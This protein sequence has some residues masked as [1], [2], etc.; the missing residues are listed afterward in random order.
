MMQLWRAVLAATIL[1]AGLGA[2]EAAKDVVVGVSWANFS[3]DRW[4][5][6]ERA[7]KA[8]LDRAGA[9]YESYDAS[10]SAAKQFVDVQKLIAAKVDV[11]VIIAIDAQALIPLVHQAE[12]QRIPVIAYDRLIDDPYAYYISF[13]SMEVGRMQARALLAAR[14]VGDYAILKGDPGDPNTGFLYSGQLEALNK[15]ITAGR[16]RNVG[17]AFITGWL[18]VHAQTATEALLAANGSN[19]DAII[20]A[21]D[22]IARGAIDALAQHGLAGRVAVSGQDGDHDALARIAIGTQTVTIWKDTRIMG[23]RAAEI[24][25][26]LANGSKTDQI[27]D[28]VIFR[29]KPSSAPLHATLLEPTPITAENLQTVIDAGWISKKDLCADIPK[30]TVNV[31][32]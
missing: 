11:L 13:D 19:V 15:P 22:S 29:S 20:A 2:A 24:A 17:E 4:T 1:L 26:A 9:K 25:L 23:Q 32:D 12:A 18:S 21:N 28:S 3:Q 10:T 16:V 6:D 31:C 5:T 8:I 30:G 27:E 7:I 14:P